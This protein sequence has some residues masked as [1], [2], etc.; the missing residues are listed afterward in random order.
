M[1]FVAYVDPNGAFVLTCSG[2]VVASNLVLTAGHCGASAS[3][4][5]PYDPSGYA[6]STGSL[7]WTDTTTRQLSGVSRVIVYPGFVSFGGGEFADGDA[8]LLQLSTPTTAPAMPLATDDDAGSY[9][10][11][12]AAAVA[13]WGFTQPGGS[14][15]AQLQWGDEVVQDSVYCTQQA[16]RLSA[17]FDSFD[18][19]CAI[20]APTNADGICSGDSG[21]PLVALD[22]GGSLIEIGITSWTESDCSTQFPDFFT[23]TDV[24]SPWIKNWIALLS[25]PSIT[26]RAA[27]DVRAFSA[28][29]NGLVDP[30]GSPTTY[31]F[32][33]G[34]T[35]AYRHTTTSTATDGAASVNAALTGLASATTYHYR[36]VGTSANGTT[37]GADQTFTTS[38]APAPGRYRGRTSQG[39]PITLRV[40]ANGQAL[41]ELAFSFDLRC[42]R[43][44]PPSYKIN[45]LGSRQSPWELNATNGLGFTKRFTDTT[46]THYDVS[47]TFDMT[48]SATGRLNATWRTPS[49]GSCRTGTVRW[50][51]T[52]G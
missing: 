9:I 30:N 14:A 22:P 25:P 50:H 7:D 33:Y 4:G 45:P 52:R 34:T 13:G 21:G 48:G 15:P 3:T 43:L 32:Q 37:D 2:T 23:R 42:T 5:V 36:L 49:Y 28:R 12:T 1:A 31:D 35:A 26:T 38:S 18:Q 8:S 20:D 11:G 39:W 41:S 17:L 24:L 6:V 47:G 27:T 46:G 44:R 16:E 29:L 40:A 51:A 10:G 19:T